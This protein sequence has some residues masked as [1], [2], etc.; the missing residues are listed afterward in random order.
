MTLRP[1]ILI[2]LLLSFAAG[3]ALAAGQPETVPGEAPGIALQGADSYVFT[4]GDVR[5]T[6]LSDGTVPQDLHKILLGTTND[7]I[8]AQ[9]AHAY[10]SNPVEMSV[11]AFLV[12]MGDRLILVDTGAG[13]MFGPGFGGKLPDSLKAAGF[14]ADD[15][16]D[17]LVTHAHSD[18]MGG[19]VHN[20]KI[21]FNNARIHIGK[22][23]VDFFMDRKNAEKSGYNVQFFDQAIQ[24]LKPYA[25][26]GK[27]NTF[28]KPTEILPGVTA[29][30]HPGHT[31]GSAFYTLESQGQTLTFVGDIIHV[32][33]V[34]F[35]DPSVTIAY[36]V[37]PDM[38]RDVRSK[39]FSAF[40]RD[41]SLVAVPHM[42]FPGVGHIRKAGK[43]YEWV[44]VNYGNR[45]VKAPAGEQ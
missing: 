11:D 42:S 36:D 16:T 20:G 26:A 43:G 39:A 32:Q 45:S 13:Q 5:V 21:I 27:I 40:A 22:P 33:A 38:A 10:Q 8:D 44:P 24:A 6:A 15:I 14:S 23:D 34:Q 4:V 18:H 19:L 2:P 3:P 1:L 30:L 41:R 7:K 28:D 35:P 37:D 17:V 12:D 25:D 29:S 31:P 9:L